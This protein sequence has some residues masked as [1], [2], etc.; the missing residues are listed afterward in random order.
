MVSRGEA[1]PPAVLKLRPDVI[2]A[3]EC[4]YFEPAF[5]LL[6]RT[7]RDLLT[8]NEQAVVFFCFKKRRR[9][10]MHFVK[11][12]KKA[13]RVD[14]LFDEERHLFQRRGLF[15][16]AFR[17]RDGSNNKAMAKKKIAITQPLGGKTDGGGIVSIR[18][19]G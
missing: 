5:P 15:L 6:M 13:F 7:L 12:A 1:L 19:V 17:A 16:F 18:Q 14:E 3:A 9:A 2:L 11:T 8:L 4:V 10:D